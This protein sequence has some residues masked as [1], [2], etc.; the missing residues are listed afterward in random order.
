MLV[1]FIDTW[2]MTE[3]G[4]LAR[5]RVPMPELA[6]GEV[7]VEIRGCGVCHT[8]LSYFYLGVPTVQKPPLSLGHE[9]AG[10]VVAGDAALA[11]REV[12]V[13]AVIPCGECE[14][15]KAGRG[16]RCLAQKMPGNSMGIHGG[17]ASHIVVPGRFLCVVGERGAIPLEHLAVVADAVTTPYQA[18]VRAGLVPGD[19]VIVIGAAGGVGSFMTQTAKAM[20]ARAVIGIDLNEAKLK[21]MEGFGADFTINPKGLSTKDVKEAIKG[22]CK[23]HGLPANFGWKIFEVTG[24]RPGQELALA[25][26]SFLGTLVVV[27]YGTEETSYMLSRLMAF[28]AQII[29]TWGCTPDKYADVL[30]MCL[31]G[32][33]RLEPFVEVQPMSRIAQVFDDAH[34]GRLDRRVV[35]TPDFD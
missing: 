2:Q 7:V 9:I 17:F 26:L 23:A 30:A 35:L 11:G 24:S 19:R 13:P 10:V 16:N 22:F 5:T 21:R 4:R 29:G 18:A 3:P 12:I 20:G 27:G 32:R 1:E 25:L 34:H 14:I 15:C 28:D 6:P 33:I 8:D 31:D